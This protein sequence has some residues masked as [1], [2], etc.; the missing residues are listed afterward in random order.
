VVRYA[1]EAALVIA[2]IVIGKMVSRGAG[3]D[4]SAK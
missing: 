3:G 2:V 1:V 4:A